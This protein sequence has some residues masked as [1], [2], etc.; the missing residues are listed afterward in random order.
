MAAAL[1]DCSAGVVPADS[2]CV[3]GGWEAW[4]AEQHKDKAAD[5][6]GRQAAEGRH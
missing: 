2:G 4:Q 6:E 3:A 1:R 5:K